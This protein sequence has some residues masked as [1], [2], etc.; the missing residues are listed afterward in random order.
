MSG[1]PIEVRCGNVLRA[2]SGSPNAHQGVSWAGTEEASVLTKARVQELSAAKQL[3]D[4]HDRFT[5]W[6]R[7]G[8]QASWDL[9]I[10]INFEAKTIE[11]RVFTFEQDAERLKRR[12]VTRVRELTK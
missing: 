4:P 10:A 5:V 9:T 11:K 3:P 2:K 1:E 7:P 8:A 12:V 6:M